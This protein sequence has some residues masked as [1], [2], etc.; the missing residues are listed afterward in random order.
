MAVLVDH[1]PGGRRRRAVRKGSG[2]SPMRERRRRSQRRKEREEKMKR[3]LWRSLRRKQ[4]LRLICFSSRGRVWYRLFSGPP[5][6]FEF[7]LWHYST[8]SEHLT[9][10]TRTSWSWLTTGRGQQGQ[11]DPQR[12]Q[13]GLLNKKST[14]THLQGGKPRKEVRLHIDCTM[15]RS[16]ENAVSPSS[17]Q[18]NTIRTKETRTQTR[19]Q[20]SRAKRLQKRYTQNIPLMEGISSDGISC[21]SQAAQAPPPAEGEEGPAEA[22]VPLTE[23]EKKEKRLEEGIGVP[24]L[25]MECQ[26]NEDVVCFDRILDTGKLASVEEVLDGLGLGPHGP[27]IPPAATFSVVPY[28]VK[29]HAP[30]GSESGH[31]QFVAT[32]PDDPWVVCFS[33]WICVV[34]LRAQIKVTPFMSHLPSTSCSNLSVPEEK[35]KEEEQEEDK[36]TIP[37]GRKDESHP[38]PQK[39]G[40]SSKAEKHQAQ[41]AKKDK[42]QGRL[43]AKGS[44]TARRGSAQALSPPPGANT[45]QSETEG[46]YSCHFTIWLNLSSLEA[47][48]KCSGNIDWQIS[49]NNKRLVGYIPYGH[50]FHMGKTEM[51]SL[52]S[53]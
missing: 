6:C 11:S 19:R 24:H 46:R 49:L 23:E 52:Q 36:S 10:P 39:G 45:P 28:P 26:P 30:P 42:R 12:P 13:R 47:I 33:S 29:R 8:G 1:T 44:R 35:P 21:H 32:G 51:L 3:V 31:Y 17:Q 34:S 27:P 22:C 14:T 48:T 4:N 50:V 2:R 5:D 20:R 41:D 7:Q 9:T 40:K 53:L 38:T 25:I 43:S 16:S 15:F 18:T 37:D